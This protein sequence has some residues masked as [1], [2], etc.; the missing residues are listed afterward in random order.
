MNGVHGVC[1]ILDLRFALD[2]FR[3]ALWDALGVANSKFLPPLCCRI[4]RPCLHL[5]LWLL[6]GTTLEMPLQRLS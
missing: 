6:L 5:L 2:G 1:E 3:R 4:S